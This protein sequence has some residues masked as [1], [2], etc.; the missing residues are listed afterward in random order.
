MIAEK[1][2]FIGSG[3]VSYLLLS[4]L[5]NNGALPPKVLLSD[6]EGDALKRVT[7]I[8]PHIIQ[9]VSP[10][11][12]TTTADIIFLAVHPTVLE[13]VATEIKEHLSTEAI[14]VS[15]LPTITISRLSQVFNGFRRIVRM[16][17]NAPSIIGKGYN[18]ISFSPFL[19]ET[20]RQALIALFENWGKCPEVTEDELEAYAILTGMGPTY[21]WFQFSEMLQL[22]RQFGLKEPHA[23]E[24]IAEMLHGAVDTLFYSGLAREQVF[25]LIP[26]HPLKKHEDEIR[27]LLNERL[28]KLYGKLREAT[29]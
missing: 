4:G 12:L 21:F 29:S 27:K 13:E 14:L 5:Q 17:P 10:N 28:T 19:K 20:E 3:R 23:K 18:P 25:D 11:N 7:Q 1:I 24:A 6:P 8:A 22:A 26:S 2:G 9:A 16:I 15:L